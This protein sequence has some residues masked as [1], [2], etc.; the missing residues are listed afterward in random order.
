MRCTAN[1]SQLVSLL[2]VFL[3][4][5]HSFVL[6]RPTSYRPT[7]LCGSPQANV[8]EPSETYP[9]IKRNMLYKHWHQCCKF[10]C[11]LS[12]QDFTLKWPQSSCLCCE[13]MATANSVDIRRC[14][15]RDITVSLIFQTNPWC[16]S[17]YPPMP[18]SLVLSVFC[19][20]SLSAHACKIMIWCPNAVN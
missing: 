9:M 13:P 18:F 12:A 17:L 20:V 11:I 3:R 1:A 6:R 14:F 19:S 2:S 10:L 5:L 8:V 7:L 4:W 15:E 16:S